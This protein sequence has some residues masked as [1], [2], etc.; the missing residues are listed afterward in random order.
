MTPT[1]QC[2]F[3]GQDIDAPDAEAVQLVGQNL[4]NRGRDEAAQAVY[5]RSRCAEEAMAAASFHLSLSST[6]GVSLFMRSC[7]VS[8]TAEG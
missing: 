4:W 5:A 1:Y 7:G 3:C 6:E 2:C 8:T